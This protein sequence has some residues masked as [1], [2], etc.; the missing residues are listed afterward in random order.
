MI[1]HQQA[2]EQ[3]RGKQ[4]QRENTRR[5]PMCGHPVII[6]GNWAGCRNSTCTG[7]K[8]NAYGAS[9]PWQGRIGDVWIG[10]WYE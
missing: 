5:C 7:G 2:R 1:A 9:R 10:D 6:S 8:P 4:A 3:V